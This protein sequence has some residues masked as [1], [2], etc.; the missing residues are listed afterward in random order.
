MDSFYETQ[1]CTRKAEETR[2]ASCT[3]KT[4]SNTSRIYFDW[5]FERLG[6]TGL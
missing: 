6:K 2:T 3:V 5:P 1:A 4:T